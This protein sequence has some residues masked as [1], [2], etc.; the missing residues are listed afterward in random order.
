MPRATLVLGIS[1]GLSIL[2]VTAWASARGRPSESPQSTESASLDP[3]HK[4]A[5]G[6]LSSLE[7]QR[8]KRALA[9]LCAAVKTN[10]GYCQEW[11]SSEDFESV[12]KTTAGIS[13]LTD[14][15]KA[16]SDDDQWQL[17]VEKL[18]QETDELVKT[19]RKA[20][21]A[22]SNLHLEKIQQHADTLAKI[23]PAFNVTPK[24]ASRN[25]I[26]RVMNLLNGTYADAKRA[27]LF[28]EVEIAQR[29][30]FVLWKVG[31]YLES[32]RAQG[33]REEAWAALATA[34][35]SASL[36]AAEMPSPGEEKLQL[37][38]KAAHTQCENCH[39][40]EQPAGSPGLSQPNRL[41]FPV[42]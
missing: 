3:A 42:R 11:L 1:F 14:L 18:R 33:A 13:L 35:S 12:L 25:D 22:Q 10:A 21:K 41:T 38:L 19:A 31:K 8:R 20:N 32:Q 23:S 9:A 2:M 37:A 17:A 40:R 5:T 16:E 4:Q 39:N 29:E 27:L 36:H 6:Q 15:L 34:F 26:R 30:A 24:Y 7:T 28:S